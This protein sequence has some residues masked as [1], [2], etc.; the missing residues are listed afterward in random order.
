MIAAGGTP[1]AT[2]IPKSEPPRLLT[3]SAS[4]ELPR[5]HYAGRGSSRLIRWNRKLAAERDTCRQDALAGR[6]EEN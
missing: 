3:F 2:V 1:S 4:R 6:S 5:A